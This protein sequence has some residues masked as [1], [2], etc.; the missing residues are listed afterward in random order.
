MKVNWQRV[1]AMLSASALILAW[2]KSAAAQTGIPVS[3]NVARPSVH[4]AYRGAA[5]ASR[6]T[7]SSNSLMRV[8]KAMAGFYSDTGRY[9]STAEG[10]SVLLVAPPGV[11]GWRGPYITTSSWAPPFTD[12]WGNQ[13]IYTNTTVVGRKATFEIRSAGPDGIL[14]TADDLA[15]QG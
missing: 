15:I 14:R 6:Q 3:P 12:P 1:A 7:A 11:R 2:D 8:Q 4:P 9:P 10:L 5:G 13:Y